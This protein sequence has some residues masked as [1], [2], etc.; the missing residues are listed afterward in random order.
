MQR[1]T[2]THLSSI[3]RMS[4]LHF[5]PLFRGT[6]ASVTDVS[7]RQHAS[8]CGGEERTASHQLIF[9]R[10]GVFVMHLERTRHGRVAEPVH[11]ML[12]NRG[13]PYRVSHPVSGGDDCTFI[14]FPDASAVDV[15]RAFDP[16]AEE[17]PGAPFSHPCAP[18]PA[19]A[20]MRFRALRR[21]LLVEDAREV[22]A[23]SPGRAHSLVGLAREVHSSPFHLT[24][25]FREVLG[26]P[27]HQYLL[28]LRLTLALHR[29]DQGERT[30]SKLA[31]DL[32]FSSHSHFATA[33]RRHFGVS[34]S[35]AARVH[36]GVR[37]PTAMQ[38]GST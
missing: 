12:V 6:L 1:S 15:V 33:F 29:L 18:L 16:S 26:M 4:L 19:D 5:Q 32:G 21:A 25:V 27:V 8:P 37:T 7:C 35:Q 14:E 20:W 13:E 9:V 10:R 34:P 31:M 11:P 3:R 22:L 24:R 36:R 2:A 30:L 23:A 17:R 38:R 28:R